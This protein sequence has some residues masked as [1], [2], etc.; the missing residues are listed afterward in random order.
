MCIKPNSHGF[1][2]VELCANV[3]APTNYICTNGLLGGVVPAVYGGAD[4][5][6]NVA[7]APSL[8]GGDSPSEQNDYWVGVA[9]PIMRAQQR[10]GSAHRGTFNAVLADESTHGISNDAALS[11]LWFLADRNDGEILNV[12]DL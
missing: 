5:V 11:S 2:L 4:Y 3:A 8:E 12:K 1:T 10:L 6:A 7:V 9:P